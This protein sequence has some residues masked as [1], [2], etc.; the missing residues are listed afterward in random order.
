MFFLRIYTF[1]D[2]K[3]HQIFYIRIKKIVSRAPKYLQDEYMTAHA[4]PKI[5]HYAG[6]D[7]PWNNP[8][9]DYAE[10]FWKYAK[11]SGYYEAI[12]YRNTQ[13]PPR[14]GIKGRTKHIAKLMLPEN[15]ARGRF[16][17]RL[18]NKSK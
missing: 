18:I 1:Y 12:I 5:I 6:P 4:N 10:A 3:I 15:T 2:S 14:V 9:A 17:R 13:V 8:L 16:V 7:K 11:D